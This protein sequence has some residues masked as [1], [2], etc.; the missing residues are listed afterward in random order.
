MSEMVNLIG[1]NKENELLEQL[2]HSKK[3]E[4]LALYGRRRVGKTF[5][6]REFFRA[7][8]DII[9]F[10]VT[11]Q[12]DAKLKEQ[13]GNFFI[14][15]NKT[16]LSKF[17]LKLAKNWNEAF[18][19]LT[20][21]IEQTPKDKKI[22]LFFDEL[23]WMATRNSRLLQALEYYWN[24]HWSDDTRIKLIVCGSSASWIIHKIIKN[25]GGLH[26]RIT[27]KICLRVFNLLG[28]QKLHSNF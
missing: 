10:N 4:F 13:I 6:I 28:F 26:N 23:P 5:L 15:M 7:K 14:Q 11:G 12:K 27:E 25:K 20:N 16:F 24:Q 3:A 22:I 8:E 9:F 17:Q 19:T 2:H 18:E 21:F 1:R